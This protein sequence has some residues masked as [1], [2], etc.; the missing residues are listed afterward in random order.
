MIDINC[1][2]VDDFIEEMDDQRIKILMVL[3]DRP[4]TLMYVVKMSGLDWDDVDD[5]LRNFNAIGV[6]DKNR[7][8][9]YFGR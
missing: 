5:E 8:L 7:R 2:L 4:H 3:D 6:C 1:D 9:S